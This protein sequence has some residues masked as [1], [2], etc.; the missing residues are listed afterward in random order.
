MTAECKGTTQEQ[1]RGGMNGKIINNKT[2]NEWQKNT[3]RRK[4]ITGKNDKRIGKEWITARRQNVS[5]I[6]GIEQ[7]QNDRR[8]QGVRI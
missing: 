2:K 4:T 3:R 8:I 6:Q 7:R 1:G 5:R